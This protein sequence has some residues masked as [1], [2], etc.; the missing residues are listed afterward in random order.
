MME[1][2]KEGQLKVGDKLKIIGKNKKSDSYENITVKDIIDNGYGEEI[3][4]NKSKN[5]Y[6]LTHLYLSGSSWCEKVYIL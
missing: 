5:H 3:I 6:F 1:I 4:I 2:T